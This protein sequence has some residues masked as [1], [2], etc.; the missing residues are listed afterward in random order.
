MFKIMKSYDH[1]QLE[2]HSQYMGC[3]FGLKNTKTQVLRSLK[4]AFWQRISAINQ[5]CV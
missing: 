2:K 5:I 1:L 4:A 3:H